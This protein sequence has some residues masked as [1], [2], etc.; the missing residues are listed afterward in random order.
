MFWVSSTQFFDAKKMFDQ[1]HT[2]SVQD[3]QVFK[4]EQI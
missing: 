4:N 3:R 2:A 1:Y